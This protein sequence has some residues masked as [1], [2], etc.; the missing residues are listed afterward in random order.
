MVRSR[1]YEHTPSERSGRAGS[2]AC[3][4]RLVLPRRIGHALE[5]VDVQLPDE[6][7]QVVVLEVQR[8]HI[9]HISR[10]R[11]LSVCNTAG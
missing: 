1:L 2:F 7:P 9:L 4:H 8:Q 5:P 10:Q 3:W 11:V 6:R